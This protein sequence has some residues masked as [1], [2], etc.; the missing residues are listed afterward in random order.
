MGSL[1]STCELLGRLRGRRTYG[2]RSVAELLT[3]HEQSLRTAEPTRAENRRS[4][5]ALWVRTWYVWQQAERVIGRPLGM[6]VLHLPQLVGLALGVDPKELGLTK[7]VVKPTAVIDWSTSVV[8]G[9]GDEPGAV[10]A[11]R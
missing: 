8:G 10:V 6:P 9:V 2:F 3:P 4:A 7:H 11:G 1:T 5:R